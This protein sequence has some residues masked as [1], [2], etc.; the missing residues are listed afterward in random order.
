MS[1]D[2]QSVLSQMRAC[3]LC[4]GE[5]ERKPNPIFQ[6]SPSARILI[7]GQAPGNLADTTAVPFNDPSGDRLRD[8]MG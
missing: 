1:G 8:W 6:L 4:E 2:L 3:R 7:V 5:M